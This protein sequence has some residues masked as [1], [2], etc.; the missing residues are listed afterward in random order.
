MTDGP[1][2]DV[3]FRAHPERYE[4]GRGEEGVLQ[5]PFAVLARRRRRLARWQNLDQKHCALPPVALVPAR[6][7][8]SLAVV[9]EADGPYRGVKA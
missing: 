4:I 8:H 3:D 5:P 1:E 9:Q 7:L 2:H 6:S